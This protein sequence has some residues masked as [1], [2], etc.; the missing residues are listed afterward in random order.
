MKNLES[1]D[2]KAPHTL[3][4]RERDMIRTMQETK[5]KSGNK[6]KYPREKSLVETKTT[7]MAGNTTT[8]VVT[9]IYDGDD[10]KYDY[11][12]SAYDDDDW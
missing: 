3:T 7:V 12:Y 11:D 4:T 1:M 5:T 8:T 2:L 9:M 6:R 10:Y